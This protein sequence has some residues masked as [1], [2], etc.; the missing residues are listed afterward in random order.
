[1]DS[2][3]LDSA[4]LYTFFSRQGVFRFEAERH[5]SCFHLEEEHQESSVLLAVAATASSISTRS[6]YSLFVT[7]FAEVFPE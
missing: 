3:I 2:E 4:K 5:S 1:M 6:Q 7:V